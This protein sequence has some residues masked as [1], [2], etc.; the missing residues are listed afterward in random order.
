MV[1]V[2]YFKK[3]VQNEELEDEAIEE[4]Y[5]LYSDKP[6]FNPPFSYL[7]PTEQLRLYK[8]AAAAPPGC[9]VEVGVFEGGSAYF[10]T[11]LA[12]QQSRKIWLYD[13]F[14]GI[15]YC[16][17]MDEITVGAI[18]ADESLARSNLGSYPTIVKCVFP[19]T[20]ELPTQRI[21]F[22][23]IDCDQYRSI[24]ESCLAIE[25]MMA[26][27][28]IIWFDD[29]AVNGGIE[30]ARQAVHEMYNGRILSDPGADRWY[31]RC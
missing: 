27:G 7:C 23:H 2:S 10:L 15:P 12:R 29:V 30:G 17:S 6:S 26:P 20:E 24:K 16:D 31:V 8:K 9:F 1:S 22:A 28:G 25:P 21:A 3:P 19:H 18:K 5:N 4:L 14:E 13:T 11:D